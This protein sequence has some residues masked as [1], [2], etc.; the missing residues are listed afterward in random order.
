MATGA[1]SYNRRFDDIGKNL[2]DPFFDS[3]KEE[4]FACHDIIEVVNNEV[5]ENIHIV[6]NKEFLR[7]LVKSH[8]CFI[9]GMEKVAN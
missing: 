6:I 1:T 7:K 9:K 4:M 2:P 8:I 3:Y 5:N